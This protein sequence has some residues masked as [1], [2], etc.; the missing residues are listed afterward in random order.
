MDDVWK[1]PAGM[2]VKAIRENRNPWFIPMGLVRQKVSSRRLYI[3]FRTLNTV[4]K[5]DSPGLHVWNDFYH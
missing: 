5:D 3:D 4:T 1:C 2:L